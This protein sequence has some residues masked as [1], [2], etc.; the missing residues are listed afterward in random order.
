MHILTKYPDVN[1]V[2]TTR[3]TES[4]RLARRMREH[5]GS[6]SVSVVFADLCNLR[7]VSTA[8]HQVV[9]EVARGGLRPLR[10]LLVAGTHHRLL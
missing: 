4:G 1:L 9:A 5:S 2:P 6:G 7:S 10:G 3:D 8:G